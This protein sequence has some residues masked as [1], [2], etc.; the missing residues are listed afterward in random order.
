MSTS[1]SQSLEQIIMFISLMLYAVQEQILSK[2]IVTAFCWW[3]ENEFKNKK[4]N[5]TGNIQETV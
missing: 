5:P 3:F 4:K 2:V 1:Y